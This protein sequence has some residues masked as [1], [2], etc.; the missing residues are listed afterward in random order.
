MRPLPMPIAEVPILS[1]GQKRIIEACER[2]W[3]AHKSNCSGFVRAVAKEIDIPFPP[4]RIQADPIIEYI[5]MWST[6]SWWKI[7]SAKDAGLFAEEGHFVLACLASTES[8]RANGHVAVVTSGY[9]P[10]KGKY[11]RGYWGALDSV[12]EKNSTMNWS[13]PMDL[14]EHK[15]SYYRCMWKR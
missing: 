4:D 6:A 1:S 12:G 5:S 14:Y 2:H 10:A 7:G 11:P 8:G 3:N 15:M 9:K 13:F